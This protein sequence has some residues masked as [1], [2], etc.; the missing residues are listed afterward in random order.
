MLGQP[1]KN[2]VSS[3]PVES[4]VEDLHVGQNRAGLFV[5]F[6]FFISV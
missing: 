4:K 5:Y 6:F 2:T 1:G 3:N